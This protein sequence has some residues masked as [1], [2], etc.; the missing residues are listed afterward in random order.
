M[1]I[2][3]RT[4]SQ[5]EEKLRNEVKRVQKY[6]KAEVIVNSLCCDCY[7][8]GEN[9]SVYLQKERMNWVGSGRVPVP[10]KALP[11]YL[12]PLLRELSDPQTESIRRL[13]EL[14]FQLFL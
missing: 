11:S 10:V 2:A 9:W 3:V 6:L 13:G 8:Y 14:V 7:G 5:I 1:A 12:E 4:K